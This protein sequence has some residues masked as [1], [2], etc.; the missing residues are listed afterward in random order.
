MA[1][2]KST[3][4]HDRDMVRVWSESIAYNLFQAKMW[5]NLRHTYTLVPVGELKKGCEWRD[6]TPEEAYAFARSRFLSHRR[7]VQTNRR[8]LA[9]TVARYLKNYKGK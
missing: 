5:F 6:A 7:Q 9:N 2:T 4:A 8:R 1:A 3:K